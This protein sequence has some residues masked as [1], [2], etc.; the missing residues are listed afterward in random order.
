MCLIAVEKTSQMVPSIS[1]EFYSVPFHLICLCDVP[2]FDPPMAVLVHLQNT[3]INSSFPRVLD[4]PLRK[5]ALK[6]SALR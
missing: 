3:L 4:S 1:P 2:F 5:T 6:R